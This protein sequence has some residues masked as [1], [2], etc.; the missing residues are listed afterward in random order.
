MSSSLTAPA[1]SSWR[2]ARQRWGPNKVAMTFAG[3]LLGVR[4]GDKVVEQ[5]LMIQV[6][7]DQFSDLGLG[8]V[9]FLAQTFILGH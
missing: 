6:V 5:L 9:A 8:L 1:W 7:L 3:T 2:V 4:W